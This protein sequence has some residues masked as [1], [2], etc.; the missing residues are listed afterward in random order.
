MDYFFA[1]RVRGGASAHCY[2]AMQHD[3]IDCFDAVGSRSLTEINALADLRPQKFRGIDFAKHSLN[4][5]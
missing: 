3:D 5:A 1:V 4:G 2:D